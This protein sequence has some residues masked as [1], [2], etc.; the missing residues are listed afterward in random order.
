MLLCMVTL[1]PLRV[2]NKIRENISGEGGREKEEHT[3]VSNI[4]EI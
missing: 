2:W 4:L 3:A 1:P